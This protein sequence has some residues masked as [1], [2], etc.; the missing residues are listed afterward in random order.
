MRTEQSHLAFPATETGYASTILT[1]Y[2]L[3]GRPPE[4]DKTSLIV[5]RSRL[6]DMLLY[7]KFVAGRRS[8]VDLYAALNDL[9]ITACQR[10]A[11][12]RPD[13][14]GSEVLLDNGRAQL[15]TAI[16]WAARELVAGSA[17]VTDAVSEVLDSGYEAMD[18]PAALG[19]TNGRLAQ[20]VEQGIIQAGSMAARW[21][22]QLS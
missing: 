19:S 17:V 15:S 21:E 12:L 10:S 11:V 16:R 6:N 14:L 9:C 3:D 7:T 8:H 20:K 18:V 22:A 2:L 13:E 1:N 5:A 4:E